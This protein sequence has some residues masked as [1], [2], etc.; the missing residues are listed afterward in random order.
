MQLV[1]ILPPRDFSCYAV[2]LDGLGRLSSFEGEAFPQAAGP[3]LSSGQGADWDTVDSGSGEQAKRFQSQY[4]VCVGTAPRHVWVQSLSG[5]AGCAMGGC[6]A[7]ATALPVVFVGS[8]RSDGSRALTTNHPYGP[9]LV[10]RSYLMW[11]A[12]RREL[13]ETAFRS[14]TCRLPVREYWTQ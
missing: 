4:G 1:S 6:R 14:T 13:W 9:S 2:P 7:R 8:A 10:A 3:D 5:R 12:T 11:D